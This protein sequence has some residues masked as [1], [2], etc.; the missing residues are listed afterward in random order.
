M[1]NKITIATRKS[2][3]ALWQAETIA[4]RLRAQ[5]PD[6]S[7]TLL[8]VSTKG[9]EILNQPL[10][11]IGGKGLFIKEL[12]VLLLSGAAD[13]AVHSL[14]DVPAE[15]ADVFTIAAVTEREDP[16]D[17]FVSSTYSCLEEMP[18]GA[19]IGTSSL[20][21]QSQILHR[22]PDLIVES[23]RGNVQTRLRKLD[24]GDYDAII[25]AAAGLIRLGKAE[26]IASFL[27]TEDSIPAAGQGIMAIETRK[28]D[29]ELIDM[30]QF[31]NAKDSEYVVSSERAF[32]GEVGGDCKVPAG[33]HA[34]L[35]DGKLFVT[36]FIASTDGKRFYKRKAVGMPDEAE[37]LGR[38][39]AK[40]LLDDGGREILT[41]IQKT[42]K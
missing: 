19:K 3:L 31:L 15:L 16:R 30:L 14:K 4:E 12:E 39:I 8:P 10:A 42:V 5:Y 13:L 23:L 38:K 20:R 32:L 35:R 2:A 18:A 29:T 7:V 11:D 1:R 40:D 36:A 21:R 6:I 17:A 27:E 37:F 41:E 28:A 33:S 25:L 24:E 34:I 26:R 9:D 22:R